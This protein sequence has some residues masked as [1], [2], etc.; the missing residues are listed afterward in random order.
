[1]IY[2]GHPKI[3]GAHRNIVVYNSQDTIRLSIHLIPEISQQDTN[4]MNYRAYRIRYFTIQKIR[5]SKNRQC[6]VKPSF[7]LFGA[8]ILLINLIPS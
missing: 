7:A 8:P 4:F 5:K 3:P 2:Y 6:G 1:M